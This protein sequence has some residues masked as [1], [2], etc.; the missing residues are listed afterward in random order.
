MTPDYETYLSPF[1]WRYGS[2]EMRSLWS[3]THKRRL[4]RRL[5]VALAE[6]QAEFGLVSPQQ[7]ADLRAHM[8]EVD[9]QR[10]FEIEASIG[11]QADECLQF[12]ER[13]LAGN[14]HVCVRSSGIPNGF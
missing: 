13:A 9:I 6:V 3:E 5:W 10:A 14:L 8:D 7:V 4:W 1:S 12:G 2:T 11:L